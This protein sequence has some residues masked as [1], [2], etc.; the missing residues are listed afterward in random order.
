MTAFS[1]NKSAKLFGT[2]M[3]L[4]VDGTSS[5]S[6][7]VILVH[8][9]VLST[10]RRYSW[11]M[12]HFNGV[13]TLCLIKSGVS[14][15]TFVLK[16]KTPSSLHGWIEDVCFRSQDFCVFILYSRC[17]LFQ[18]ACFLCNV[19]WRQHFDLLRLSHECTHLIS[20]IQYLWVS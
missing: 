20:K 11:G 8:L 17:C 9:I 19:L 3:G 16:G 13:Y 4:Y 10:Y 15:H 5:P 18:S 7:S 6:A 2:M 14:V 12:N 1:K